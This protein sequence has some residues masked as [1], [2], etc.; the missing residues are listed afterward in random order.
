M[1]KMMKR[2][3]FM[4]L[5]LLAVSIGIIYY[6]IDLDALKTI[7]SFNSISLLL[8]LVALIVGMYFDGLRL[9]R[10]VKIGGYK[11]S[12]KAVLRVIFSNYFMAMLTP[13]ASAQV[14]VLR[15]Y[16]VPISKGTPIV[17]IRTVFSIMFLVIM[18]P[19][20]FLRDAIEIPYIS[21]DMLLTFAVVSVIAMLVGTYILQTKYMRQF[22]YNLAQRFKA[23]KTKD[24]LS[25]LET[26]NQGLGLLYKQPIQ[27]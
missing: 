15:S 20:V 2:G 11:L 18:L 16:G 23:H 27:S 21:R 26:L 17:L 1:S 12:I 24:W 3:I 4:F 13:G 25:K 9:Q 5:L 22:V 8:A 19:F 10:L 7:S 6:T 14:L